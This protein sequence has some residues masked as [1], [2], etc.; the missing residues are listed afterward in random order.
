MGQCNSLISLKVSV[1]LV[2]GFGF[3]VCQILHIYLFI[4][5][6][7]RDKQSYRAGPGYKTNVVVLRPCL[8]AT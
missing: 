7:E 2:V 1:V 5:E 3:G 4:L 8:L 6:N